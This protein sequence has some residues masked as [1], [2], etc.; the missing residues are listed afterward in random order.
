MIL[1]AAKVVH[2]SGVL[3]MGI[4][5]HESGNFKY[6]YVQKDHGSPSYGV[7]QIKENSAR[8][9]GFKGT[10]EELM[11]SKINIKYAAKYLKYEQDRYGEDGWIYLV[12][13]YNAG[14]YIEN[15]RTGCPKNMRYI[16][17]VQKKLPE[18]FRYKLNCGDM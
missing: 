5:S 15:K 11:H 8:Q 17:L 16:R 10:T 13:A 4:C 12:S 7:C 14:S 2:V 6:N 9:M 1:E 3:L 18:P